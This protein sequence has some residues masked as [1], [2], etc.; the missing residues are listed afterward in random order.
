MGYS[1]SIENKG[2]YLHI[3]VTGENTPE[4][5][6]AYLRDIYEAC[7]REHIP[8]V[9]IEESLEGPPLEPV[10]VYRIITESSAQTSP[11][12]HK[13]AYVDINLEHPY[14]ISGWGKGSPVIA[15]STFAH[16]Q[17]SLLQW[18]GSPTLDLPVSKKDLPS[19]AA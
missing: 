15:V 5:L 17:R 7:A 12:I 9:L 11:V 19:C 4:T 3:R 13:I 14:P 6:R 16:S 1:C 2:P 18:S 10:D 8:D